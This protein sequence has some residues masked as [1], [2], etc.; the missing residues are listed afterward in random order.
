MY[1]CLLERTDGVYCWWWM[2]VMS[3]GR[4]TPMSDFKLKTPRITQGPKNFSFEIWIMT[5]R[6]PACKIENV[7]T[8]NYEFSLPALSIADTISSATV[9]S[10]CVKALCTRQKDGEFYCHDCGTASKKPTCT[11][12]TSIPSEDDVSTVLLRS[13]THTVTKLKVLSRNHNHHSP[14]LKF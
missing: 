6:P 1:T 14:T 5:A 4:L 10:Q 8:I 2:Y 13:K 7:V 12:R 3:A 11:T 9:Y